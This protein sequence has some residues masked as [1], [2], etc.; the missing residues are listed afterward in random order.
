MEVYDGRHA[1]KLTMTRY[2]GY[3]A[4]DSMNIVCSRYI[5]ERGLAKAIFN[6]Q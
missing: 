6:I 2:T 3:I 5:R 1:V 4:E